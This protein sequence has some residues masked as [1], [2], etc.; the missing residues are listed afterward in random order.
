MLLAGQ[1]IRA[2]ALDVVVTALVQIGPLIVL[3][4]AIVWLYWSGDTTCSTVLLIWSCVVGTL[5]NVLRPVLI[6][7]GADL[8]IILIFSGVIGGPVVLAVSYRLVCAGCMKRRCRQ[9]ILPSW[10]IFSPIT[11]KNSCPTDR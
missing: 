8:P 5:D 3:V 11:I 9:T 1:A 7:I 6:R 10:W 2:V 4:P